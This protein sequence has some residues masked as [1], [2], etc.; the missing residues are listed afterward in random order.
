M[1]IQRSE[2]L[3]ENA[4][5]TEADLAGFREEGQINREFVDGRLR[6]SS[7]KTHEPELEGHGNFVLWSDAVL[8]DHVAVSEILVRPTDQPT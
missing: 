4:L 1:E 7:R 6:L 8:P 2:L 3:Y 5:A